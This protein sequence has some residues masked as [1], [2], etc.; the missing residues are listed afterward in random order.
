LV[1]AAASWWRFG[2]ATAINRHSIALSFHLSD[3][4][5][6]TTL[7]FAYTGPEALSFMSCEIKDA[8]RIAPKALTLA[9]PVIVAV[10]ILGTWSILIAIPPERAGGVYG[11]IEAIRAA[12]ANLGL[13]WLV[14]L[15]A[16]C[17]A[18]DRI[19]SLCL[20]LGALARIPASAGIA[21]YLPRG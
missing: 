9:A 17:V 7:A 12:A 6:W 14:P 3:V 10:Y 2:P 19:G 13:G 16:A 11:V 18:L 21:D 1:L 5:F 4:I 20:W 8:R 15:G